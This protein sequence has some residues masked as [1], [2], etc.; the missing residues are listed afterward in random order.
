MQASALLDPSPYCVNTDQWNGQS[1][2]TQGANQAGSVMSGCKLCLDALEDEAERKQAREYIR[3]LGG[4]VLSR[5][6]PAHMQFWVAQHQK[7]LVA[8]LFG[9]H[10]MREQWL[11]CAGDHCR[12]TEA[13]EELGQS[14]R[15]VPRQLSSQH[16][17]GTEATESMLC[18]CGCIEHGEHVLGEAVPRCEAALRGQENLS[19]SSYSAQIADSR[20]F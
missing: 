5:F 16:N 20:L 10:S 13:G 19:V 8:P 6:Q 18:A 17:S 12:V 15:S 14:F 11:F 9:S 3:T 7:R 4:Q 2:A 1:G